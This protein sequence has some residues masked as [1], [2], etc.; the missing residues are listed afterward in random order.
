MNF[1]KNPVKTFEKL[2]DPAKLYLLL[3]LASVVVYTIHYFGKGKQM[4][5]IQELGIQVIVMFIWTCILNKI[6]TFK[7]GVKISWFLV[8]LP[9]IFMI[10]IL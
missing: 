6:C 8:F 10:I 5:S 3:S 7:H 1:M 2:C 4:Y 9:I